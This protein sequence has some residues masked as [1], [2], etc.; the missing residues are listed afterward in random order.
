MGW[1]SESA[2]E[3]SSRKSCHQIAG[4]S[5]PNAP[6]NGWTHGNRDVDDRA[7]TTT[8]AEKIPA[9]NYLR[10]PAL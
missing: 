2:R 4:G 3:P 1:E 10:L 7:Q 5:K 6:N 8:A 9:N